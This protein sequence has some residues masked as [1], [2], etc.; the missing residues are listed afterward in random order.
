VLA[1][2]PT[3]ATTDVEDIDGRPLGGA[4]GRS[5]SDHHRN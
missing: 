3:A 2:G 1:A 4:G 5:G